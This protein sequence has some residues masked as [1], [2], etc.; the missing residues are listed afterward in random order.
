VVRKRYLIK[1]ELIYILLNS[2]YKKVK[3]VVFKEFIIKAK[4]RRHFKI[5]INKKYGIGVANIPQEQG[6]YHRLMYNTY[7][8]YRDY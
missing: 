8:L 5:F 2:N 6:L 1:K 3:I 7:E 4:T